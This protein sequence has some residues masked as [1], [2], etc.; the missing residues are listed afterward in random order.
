MAETVL[1]SLKRCLESELESKSLT[2]LP[3]DFYSKLATYS[4]RIKRSSGSGASEVAVRLAASQ[5]RMID[6]MTGA[7]LGL[8][9]GKATKLGAAL[10]LLPEERYVCS[11]EQK[12]RRRFET[13]VNA[14]SSGKPSFIEFAHRVE[15]D[16]NMVV[17]FI[18]P[19]RELVGLDLRRYGPF[20]RDD[21]AS[22]PADSAEVLVTGGD[23]VEVHTRDDA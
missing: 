11:S 18:K 15:A 12:H 22:I 23:A 2:I 4:M 7:L 10:Q 1:E 13:F 14:V 3:G 6:S 20:D 5:A 8:R 16:R 17:R 21:V 19:V 9:T